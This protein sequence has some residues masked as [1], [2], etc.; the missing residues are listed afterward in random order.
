M[1][2]FFFD[3][4]GDLSAH[5]YVGHN[6]ASSQEAKRHASFIAQRIGAEQVSL[7]RPGNYISVRDEGGVEIFKAPIIPSGAGNAA[8]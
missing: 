8:K 5:D 6:C 7:A 2:R 4:S 3:L 1:K